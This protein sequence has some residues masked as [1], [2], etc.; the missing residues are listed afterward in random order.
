MSPFVLSFLAPRQTRNAA[1]ARR[2]LEDPAITVWLFHCSLLHRAFVPDERQRA[3]WTIDLNLI[4]RQQKSVKSFNV[5]LIRLFQLSS[6]WSLFCIFSFFFLIYMSSF[7]TWAFHGGWE[8]RNITGNFSMNLPRRFCFFCHELARTSR[9]LI[10][11]EF[12]LN[13]P[14]LT[15]HIT[16]HARFL[17][18]LHAKSCETFNF[19]VSSFNSFLSLFHFVVKF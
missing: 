4:Q 12:C 1:T 2:R 13:E 18:T 11:K 9:N 14:L 10:Q 17:F 8:G 3:V 19:I 6:L 15:I 7:F 5:N 16:I